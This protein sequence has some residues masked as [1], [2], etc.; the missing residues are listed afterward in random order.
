MLV[1]GS[2]FEEPGEELR[3]GM[4]SLALYRPFVE[5]LAQASGLPVDFSMPGTLEIGADEADLARLS[6]RADKQRAFGVPSS[7]LPASELPQRFSGFSRPLGGAVFYPEEGQVDPRSVIAA[8]RA[9]YRGLP[10]QLREHQAVVELQFSGHGVVA[11]CANGDRLSARYAVLAAGAWATQVK[12][13]VSLPRAY[14][15]K[16]HLLGYQAAP[17]SLGYVLRFHETYIVQR[18]SGYTIAGTSVEDVGFNRT[19]DAGIVKN[20]ASRAHDLAG[21]LL[22][23]EPRDAWVGFRPA[24]ESPLPLI[25]RHEDTPLYLAYGHF[26]NGILWAPLTAKR[27]AETI[28]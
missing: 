9:A 19:V 18:L 22:P 23:G 12:L 11:F 21:G 20:I 26:R 3:L 13:P 28:G 8:L 27:L 15:I 10:V 25:G 7:I 1:P 24:A 17:G 4:E 16:G 6:R 2:E 14:P 5:E